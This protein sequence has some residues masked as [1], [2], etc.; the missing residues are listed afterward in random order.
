MKEGRTGP[1][2]SDIWRT[3]RTLIIRQNRDG[4]TKLN[5]MIL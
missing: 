4:G 1:V 3:S 2:W 5:A